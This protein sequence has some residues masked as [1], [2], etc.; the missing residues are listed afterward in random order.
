M[1]AGAEAAS[2]TPL[3]KDNM[4]TEANA[5]KDE[6]SVTIEV[7]A[8]QLAIKLP[9]VET[10]NEFVRKLMNAAMN[11]GWPWPVPDGVVGKRNDPD[12]DW[13]LIVGTPRQEGHNGTQ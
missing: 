8:P 10:F 2:S 5:D 3:R 4:T 6:G 12:Q 7:E 1:P 13:D 11:L 9:D